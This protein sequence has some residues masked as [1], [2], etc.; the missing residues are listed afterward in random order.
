MAIGTSTYSGQGVSGERSQ[1][2]ARLHTRTS[3][4]CQA[5]LDRLQGME[6]EAPTRDGA[7]ARAFQ[8]AYGR[9]PTGDEREACASHWEQMKEKHQRLNFA[10]PA[11][12]QEILREAVEENTGE[13]F[14]FTEPLETAADFVPDLKMS[15][16]SPEIRALADVCLVLLNS[17]EFAYVY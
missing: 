14:T 15:D 9:A 12:P 2:A 10:P 7:V 13:K 8:L 11:I 5:I 3:E 17:N 6:G 16:V 4:V 1:L